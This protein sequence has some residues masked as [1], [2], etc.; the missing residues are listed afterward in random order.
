V[1][2]DKITQNQDA[3]VHVYDLI[4]FFVDEILVFL[5]KHRIHAGLA[6][7]GQTYPQLYPRFL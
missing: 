6:W 3:I 4:V 5:T 1:A 2:I 7:S